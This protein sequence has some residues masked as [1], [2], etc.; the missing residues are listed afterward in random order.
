MLECITNNHLN[1]SEIPELMVISQHLEEYYPD[2]NTYVCPTINNLGYITASYYLQN[3]PIVV[4]YA[5]DRIFV[6]RI[7]HRREL[8]DKLTLLGKRVF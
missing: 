7:R 2:K 1:I 4:T 8:A 3:R 6:R 5:N